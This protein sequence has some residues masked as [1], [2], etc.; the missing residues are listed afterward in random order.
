MVFFVSGYDAESNLWIGLYDPANIGAENCTCQG[1]AP[2]IC[3]RCRDHF[4]W[5]DGTPISEVFSPWNNV[6]PQLGERCVRLTND[7]DEYWRAISCWSELD[8]ACSRGE[9]TLI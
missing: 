4:L 5:S 8:Y 2:A 7:E 1:V 6:E 9:C 3:D